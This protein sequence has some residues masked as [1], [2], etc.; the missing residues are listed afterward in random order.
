MLDM[1]ILEQK[2]SVASGR[3][4][5]NSLQNMHVPMLDLLVRE[6]IQN[7]SDAALQ[8]Q[9]TE[10]FKV[11]FRV[12]EFVSKKFSS[13]L[14]DIE[15]TLN[16]NYP[17]G[18]ASYLE[19]RDTNTTGLTG[20]VR[21]QSGSDHG[22]FVKLIFDYGVKQSQANAGGNWGFGKSV[23]YRLGI[24]LVVFYSQIKSGDQ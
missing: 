6:A 9:D 14:K 24:G 21:I 7:S 4:T 1:S 10:C 18:K 23:Y 13:L 8:V 22:N 2:A 12:G 11:N 19:I 5:L 17:E 16:K 3:V 15:G 20:P